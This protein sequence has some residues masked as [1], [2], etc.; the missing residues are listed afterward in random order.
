MISR[1]QIVPLLLTACPS[2]QEPWRRYIEDSLYEPDLIYLHLAEFS[3]HLINLLQGQSCEEFPAVFEV[4][5][6]LH[7]EGDHDTREIATIGI[8]ETIQNHAGHANID[9][10]SF[11]RWLGP[12]SKKWW[13][14]L[15]RFWDGDATAL[16]E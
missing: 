8:L 6:R 15:D 13:D 1:D 16:Q 3:R 4:I 5:E 11:T 12:E 10:E 14:R 2:F 9:S 7:I